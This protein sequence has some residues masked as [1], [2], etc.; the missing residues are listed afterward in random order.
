M[1]ENTAK[2]IVVNQE[3]KAPLMIKKQLGK[4]ILVVL[5]L[6]IV[7]ELTYFLPRAFKEA[8]K[9]NINKPAPLAGAQIALVSSKKVYSLGTLVPVD[10]NIFTGGYP[11]DGVDVIINY[12]N[13]LLEASSGALVRGSIYADYPVMAVDQ[14]AGK[15]R[16]S[17]ISGLSGKSFNG[18]GALARVN[19][20]AK[21]KGLAKLM[22]DFTKGATTD[23]N[24]TRSA[25][26][27]NA[28]QDS[29]DQ[30]FNLEVMIR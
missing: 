25:S 2:N 3:V 18:L 16:I 13:K 6:V 22:L 21:N 26:G 23:S 20:K 17:A 11:T 10:I 1:D 14:V 29:L 30:I 4:I 7:G 28:A 9:V 5:A 12:D 15:I 8:P 24:I 27:T 19:F